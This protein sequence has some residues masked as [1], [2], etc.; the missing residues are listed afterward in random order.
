MEVVSALS[1]ALAG[2]FRAKE[3]MAKS[4]ERVASGDISAE[5]LVQSK[6]DAL[7]VKTQTKNVK[8][9]MEQEEDLLDIIA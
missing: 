1:N 9:M 3:N 7:D 8:L 4:A 2:L 5:S 6:I